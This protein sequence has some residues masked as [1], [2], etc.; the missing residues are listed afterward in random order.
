MTRKT[1][2]AG[3][4][5]AAILGLLLWWMTPS[6]WQAPLI[7]LCIAAMGMLG[8]LVM[9]AIKRDR[10]IKDWG[11]NLIVG[12]GSMLDKPESVI[13]AAP[14]FFHIIHRWWVVA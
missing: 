4:G 6:L 8:N 11:D 12:Y 2:A 7:A 1:V 3:F 5:S 14:I 10:G 9:A 13:F